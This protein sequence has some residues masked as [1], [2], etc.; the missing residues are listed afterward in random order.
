MFVN[1][2]VINPLV[3]LKIVEQVVNAT[4]IG[5]LTGVIIGTAMEDPTIPSSE[6]VIKNSVP[7]QAFDN[8]VYFFLRLFLVLPSSSEYLYWFVIG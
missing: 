4:E 8:F 7:R 1:F 3:D 5:T 6:I 2:F